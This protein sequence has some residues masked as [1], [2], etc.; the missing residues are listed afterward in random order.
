MTNSGIHIDNDLLAHMALHH[1]PV[2]HHTTKQVIIAT[3]KSSNSALTLTGVLSQ[4]HELIRDNFSSSSTI[5]ALNARAKAS[6][7]RSTSYKRCSNGQ[8][9]PK[10]A[11]SEESCWQLHPSKNPHHNS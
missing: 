10:T 11:H 5:T 6:Y 2:K 4:M 7:L 1:L 3:Y 9:N 8:H